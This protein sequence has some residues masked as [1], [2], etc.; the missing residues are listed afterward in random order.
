MEASRAEV[1]AAVALEEGDRALVCF[2]FLFI[3]VFFFALVLLVLA[4]GVGL[5][6][7]VLEV[8]GGGEKVG[9]FLRFAL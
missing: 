2:N 9:L 4:V 8:G 6:V 7:G 3:F 5:C 1:A